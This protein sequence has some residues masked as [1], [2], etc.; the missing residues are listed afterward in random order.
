MCFRPPRSRCCRGAARRPPPW[1]G[2]A[3]PCRPG[4]SSSS[5]RTSCWSQRGRPAAGPSEGPTSCAEKQQGTDSYWRLLPSLSDIHLHSLITWST[6]L[7]S[8]L[9]T[10]QLTWKL[11]T[12]LF[13]H[14]FKPFAFILAFQLLSFI[15]SSATNSP[16][17]LPSFDIYLPLYLFSSLCAC[18]AVTVKSIKNTFI[19]LFFKIRLTLSLR[20][21]LFPS[22]Q[23]NYSLVSLCLSTVTQNYRYLF[24]LEYT[25][26]KNSKK[27][28]KQRM[29]HL[30]LQQ[31]EGRKG[32]KHKHLNNPLKNVTVW[33]YPLAKLDA[34]RSESPVIELNSKLI[35][36]LSWFLYLIRFSLDFHWG[37]WSRIK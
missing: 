24:L 9:L 37:S 13:F 2:P 17:L 30:K 3:S 25:V 6:Y 23:M 22:F 7:A 29:K 18:F 20:F 21:T 28:S 36:L 11:F 1:T 12:L 35:L 33:W 19:A 31:R 34:N 14:P 8:L 26:Q 32:R 4:R 15:S 16:S 10:H 27:Q 5:P